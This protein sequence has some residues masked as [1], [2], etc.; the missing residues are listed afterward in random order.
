MRSFLLLRLV[1]HWMPCKKDACFCRR[2]LVLLRLALLQR[3]PNLPV[4]LKLPLHL[5][6]LLCPMWLHPMLLENA[7]L[8]LLTAFANA[9]LHRPRNGYCPTRSATRFF[10]ESR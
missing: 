8:D 5:R 10:F 7:V 1:C 2:V 9:A 6:Q 4:A 3:M